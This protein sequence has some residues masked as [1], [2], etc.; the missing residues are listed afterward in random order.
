MFSE[1]IDNEI[2]IITTHSYKLW[3]T[4][5]CT[6]IVKDECYVELQGANDEDYK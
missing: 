3:Y 2:C 1:F 6:V 5:L 4:L